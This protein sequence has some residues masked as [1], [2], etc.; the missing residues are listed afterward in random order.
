MSL[1]PILPLALLLFALPVAAQTPAAAPAP[2]A[3]PAAAAPATAEEADDE[4]EGTTVMGDRESPIGLLIAP[5]REAAPEKDLDRPVRF[6]QEE[7]MP[8]DAEV[9]RRQTEYY[10]TIAAHLKSRG[11]AGYAEAL[12]S[13]GPAAPEPEDLQIGAPPVVPPAAQ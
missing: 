6:L 5:W 1:R 13:Q 3:N 12:K 8:L 4:S 10:Y 11:V 9:F 2:G 7:L